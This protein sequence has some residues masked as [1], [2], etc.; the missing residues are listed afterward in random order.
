MDEQTKIE[1]VV[2]H[3]PQEALEWLERALQWP[4]DLEAYDR[5]NAPIKATLEG[6]II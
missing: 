1:V 2:I 3:L 4:E 5:L 6:W